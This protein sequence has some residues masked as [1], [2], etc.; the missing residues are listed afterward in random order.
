VGV[1]RLNEQNTITLD[2]VIPSFRADVE[3]MKSIRDLDL[4]NGLLRTM[5]IV[6]DDPAHPIPRE[7]EEWE[8]SPNITIIRNDMNL[9]ANGSRN[10]GI[11]EARADWILF[12]DDDIVPEPN[13]LHVYAKA[14]REHG[15]NVPGFVGV[16]RFPEPVNGFTEGV[17]ASDILTFFDLAVTKEEMPWGVTA[18]LLVK[19]AAMDEHRFRSCFPNAGGGEDIDFCLEIVR[20]TGARFATEPSAVV[21]HPWWNDANRSYRRFFRWAYGDSRLPALHPQHRWRNLPNSAEMLAILLLSILPLKILTDVSSATLGFAVCGLIIGDWVTEWI[22]LSMV[23][24]TYYPRTAIESSMV[25][26]SNDLGRVRAVVESFKPWRITER[27]DYAATGEWI[28]GERRWS[29]LRL[30]IQLGLVSLIL[31]LWGDVPW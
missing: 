3:V 8:R 14:I 9:G 28:G 26:F 30:V 11:E 22:K 12:L 17:V 24:S 20:T 2:I 16:T 27:F 29:L 21:H 13:L 10:R 18:N 1:A 25:R 6:L 7:F 19:R 23:K 4:P 5:I 31:I 15:G